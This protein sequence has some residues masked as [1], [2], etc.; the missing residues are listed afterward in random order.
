MTALD[1][2][3]TELGTKAVPMPD[4]LE[5]DVTPVT[6]LYWLWEAS[7]VGLGIATAFAQNLQLDG[8]EEQ[9]VIT[10][11]L[12]GASFALA[13][14]THALVALEVL[15]KEVEEALGNGH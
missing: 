14:M 12:N 6:A 2:A 1:D 9:P 15:P 11:L 3:R 4:F 5:E 13:G 10:E 7:K 8:D